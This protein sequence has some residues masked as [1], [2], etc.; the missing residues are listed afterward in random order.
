MYL[1]NF[2]PVNSVPFEQTG[3]FTC[4]RI[5]TNQIKPD[6]NKADSLFVDHD[7]ELWRI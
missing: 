2:I 1:C 5:T 6:G 3:P 7:T 4:N